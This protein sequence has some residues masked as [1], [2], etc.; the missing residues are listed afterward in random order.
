M[1]RSIIDRST[2]CFDHLATPLQHTVDQS[3]YATLIQ[4]GPG[5]LQTALEFL[6]RGIVLHLLVGFPFDAIPEVLEGDAVGGS[7]KL[8]QSGDLARSPDCN[9]LWRNSS[10][11]CRGPGPTWINVAYKLW[12][13]VCW[14]GDRSRWWTH[15]RT[16]PISFRGAEFSCPN[17]FSIACPKIKWFCPNITWFPLP[18]PP[19]D[20]GYLKNSRG[21]SPPASYAYGW[22]Y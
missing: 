19:P 2:I 10:A 5:P 12:S 9:P 17:I 21:A 16:G 11:F 7:C 8:Q 4:V 15:G 3:L 14:R 6:Q 22:T 1:K 20:Y 18:P 13:T